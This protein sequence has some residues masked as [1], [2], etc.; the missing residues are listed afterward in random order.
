MVLSQGKIPGHSGTEFKH[1]KAFKGRSLFSQSSLPTPRQSGNKPLSERKFTPIGKLWWGMKL[2][3]AFLFVASAVS[4]SYFLWD[5]HQQVKQY[6]SA[7]HLQTERTTQEERQIR[8]DFLL[9][10]GDSYRRAGSWN[11]AEEEYRL[12]LQAQ[13]EGAGALRAMTLTLMAK[14]YLYQTDCTL[15]R[16]YLARL[17][18]QVQKELEE[19]LQLEE[20]LQLEQ[21]MELT[22]FPPAP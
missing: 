12:A 17:S 13:P 22:S 3:Q 20:I 1:R 4:V 21:A 11:A 10:K 15:A 14:C 18:H 7:L 5:S 8:Y 2:F 19:A 6:Q 9:Y 16:T